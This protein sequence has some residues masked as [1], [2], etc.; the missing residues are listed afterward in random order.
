[1]NRA[2][3][4]DPVEFERDHERDYFVTWSCRLC[5]WNGRS[6]PRVREA[7]SLLDAQAIAKQHGYGR[8]VP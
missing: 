8:C 7:D 3:T 5:R 6:T 2:F 4:M 1:M